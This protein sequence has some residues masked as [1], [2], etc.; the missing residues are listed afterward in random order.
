MQSPRSFVLQLGVEPALGFGWGENLRVRV[1]L[2]SIDIRASELSALKVIWDMK[3][4]VFSA[5]RF[6]A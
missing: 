1:D 2:E 5:C 4:E 6:D 3:N